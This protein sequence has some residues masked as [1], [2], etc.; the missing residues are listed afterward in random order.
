MDK[1]RKHVEEEEENYKEAK[2]QLVE[3]LHKDIGNEGCAIL[4]ATLKIYLKEKK[5]I[6]RFCKL[7]TEEECCC[8]E[9]AAFSTKAIKGGVMTWKNLQEWIMEN[10]DC[11]LSK[12]LKNSFE[13]MIVNFF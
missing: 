10:K 3:D 1:K 2:D 9:L 11:K 6:K 12:K 4:L 8:E 13:S 7:N 5:P